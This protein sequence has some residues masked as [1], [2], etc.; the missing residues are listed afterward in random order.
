MALL[1]VHDWPG[2]IR[3]LQNV[4]RFLLVRCREDVVQPCH[5][6]PNLR[7]NENRD[8]QVVIRRRRQGK[9]EQSAV[10][11][12]LRQTGNNRLQA[13]RLLGVSRATIYRFLGKHPMRD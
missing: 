12:A 13:A 3:E 11:Q 7:H 1:R 8:T 4:I 5:L 10:R 6:P 9:L 2:N